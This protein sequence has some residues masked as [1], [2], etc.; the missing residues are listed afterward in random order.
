MSHTQDHPAHDPKVS[1]R[2]QHMPGAL[3]GAAHGRTHQ[4]RMG[5]C[6]LEMDLSVACVQ[7][8]TFTKRIERTHTNLSCALGI[9]NLRKMFISFVS[10]RGFSFPDFSKFYRKVSVMSAI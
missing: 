7:T 9:S 5:R 1:P 8:P 6:P 10:E 2:C 3:R 4:G